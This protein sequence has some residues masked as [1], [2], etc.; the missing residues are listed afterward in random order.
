MSASV[1]RIPFNQI[2]HVIYRIP[3][4]PEFNLL[5]SIEAL[6]YQKYHGS[7][8]C[9]FSYNLNG[10]VGYHIPCPFGFERD[11]L[12]LPQKPVIY[13]TEEE[14]DR[15]VNQIKMRIDRILKGRRDHPFYS[16]AVNA[17]ESNYAVLEQ[18]RDDPGARY[19]DKHIDLCQNAHLWSLKPIKPDQRVT[20]LEYDQLEELHAEDEEVEI[21]APHPYGLYDIF[22]EEEYNLVENDTRPPIWSYNDR[23]RETQKVIKAIGQMEVYS[24]CLCFKILPNRVVGK[25]LLNV[26]P[27][28]KSNHQIY[29]FIGNSTVATITYVDENGNKILICDYAG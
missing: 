9:L 18:V 17:V 16:Q 24:G 12:H 3:R 10:D 26:L 6:L 25:D 2:T 22:G 7:M 5:L 19:V 20:Y 28:L 23:V 8:V 21:E 29:D 1:D 13:T 11:F 4:M 14:E 15:Y 27:F